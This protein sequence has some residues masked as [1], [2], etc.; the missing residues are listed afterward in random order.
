MSSHPLHVGIVA[1]EPSGDRL[2]AGLMQAIRERV[3]DAVFEGV[4]G[5][6]M[7]EAGCFSLHPMEK[8]S[9]MGLTNVI[10]R[11]TTKGGQGINL[12]GHHEIRV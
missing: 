5:T 6:R 4:G 2:G 9:V 12:V 7:T 11:P 3:P 10:N 8:L 1:G